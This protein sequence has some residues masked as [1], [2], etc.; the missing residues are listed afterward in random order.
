VPC[1]LCVPREL[2]AVGHGQHRRGYLVTVELCWLRMVAGCLIVS[3]EAS[4]ILL[5]V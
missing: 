2:I 3:K 1:D 5:R 4:D